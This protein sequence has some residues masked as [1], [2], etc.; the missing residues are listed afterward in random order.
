MF[1]DD[2]SN[3]FFLLFLSSLVKLPFLKIPDAPKIA[4]LQK[5]QQD[6]IP[7]FLTIKQII[8]ISDNVPKKLTVVNIIF[9]SSELNIKVII[10]IAIWR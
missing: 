5:G 4:L 6:D 3:H 7:I 9:C 1:N 8:T 10:R 2:I